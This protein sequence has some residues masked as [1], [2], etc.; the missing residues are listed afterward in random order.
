MWTWTDRLLPLSDWL[1]TW[2][3]PGK[4]R[5]LFSQY[6]AGSRRERERERGREGGRSLLSEGERERERERG[7]APSVCGMLADRSYIIA[8]TGRVEGVERGD[9]FF[10]LQA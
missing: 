9:F 6:Q 5:A 1:T 3:V 10:P 4:S 7:R 8:T 2:P